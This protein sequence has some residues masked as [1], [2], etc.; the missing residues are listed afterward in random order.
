MEK[1]G[2][3]VHVTTIEV[4]KRSLKLRNEK[5]LKRLFIFFDATKSCR[6]VTKCVPAFNGLSSITRLRVAG[7][8]TDGKVQTKQI[9]FLERGRSRN[10]SVLSTL[11]WFCEIV[12]R[13]NGRADGTCAPTTCV[14]HWG[15]LIMKL[16]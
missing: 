13:G 5:F 12:S 8:Q 11:P 15:T 4:A 7:E 10:I 6:K 14:A 2:H 16:T 1:T 9:A 3:C